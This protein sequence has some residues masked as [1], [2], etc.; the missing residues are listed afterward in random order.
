MQ[1][2]KVDFNEGRVARVEYF[3]G[4]DM[5]LIVHFRDGSMYSYNL[6]ELNPEKPWIIV[7]NMITGIR[8]ETPGEFFSKHIKNKCS[9]ARLK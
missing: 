8:G 1:I 7:F 9:Y 5:P 6:W 3:G 4:S 2:L